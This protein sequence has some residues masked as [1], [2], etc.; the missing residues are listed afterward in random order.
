LKTSNI[1][2]FD[3][4][5]LPGETDHGVEDFQENSLQ[6]NPSNENFLESGFYKPRMLAENMMVE[7]KL[8]DFANFLVFI[9]NLLV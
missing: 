9:F 4:Y 1:N 2:F 7:S 6:K 8:K 3:L 5:S